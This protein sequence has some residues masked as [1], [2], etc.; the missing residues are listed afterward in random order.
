MRSFVVVV[1]ALALFCRACCCSREERDERKGKVELQHGYTQGTSMAGFFKA[2]FIEI[3]T[4][5][6]VGA[7][8]AG[9][10]RAKS[11]MTEQDMRERVMALQKDLMVKKAEQGKAMAE[12]KQGGRRSLSC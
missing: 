12:K 7:L 6:F 11:V 9:L 4:D 8:K 1:L 10:S 2:Q 3:D 5:T